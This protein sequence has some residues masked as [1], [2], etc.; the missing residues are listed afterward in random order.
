MELLI[1]RHGQSQADLED[2]HEGRADFALTQ[3][4]V[5]QAQLLAE[6]VQERFPPKLILSSPLQRA[7]R[8]AEILRGATGAPLQLEPALME[9]NN[10]LLAGLAR[11]EAAERFPLPPGGR[12]PT[13]PTLRPS[14][15]SSSGHG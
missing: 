7:S 13:I 6:W 1:I 4:G 10:G 8:T 3:L 14:P 12:R 9:W 2:R 5:K 15:S 11:Q